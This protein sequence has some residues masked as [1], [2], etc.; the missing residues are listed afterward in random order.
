[1]SL[2]VQAVGYGHFWRALS[3]GRL[4]CFSTPV[5]TAVVLT[6][7]L[8]IALIIAGAIR[9]V[10]AILLKPITGWGWTLFSGLLTLATGIL[11]LVSK[12][13]PFGC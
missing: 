2:K 4:L 6:S 5:T 3:N 1:M 7:L 12:D 13:S 8:S 10:N 9:T 11:I